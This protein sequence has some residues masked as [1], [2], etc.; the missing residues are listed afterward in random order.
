MVFAL[1][2]STLILVAIAAADR[3]LVTAGATF[4]IVG[5]ALFAP[6]Q[7]ICKVIWVRVDSLV[8]WVP[9][10]ILFWSLKVRSRSVLIKS[11]VSTGRVQGNNIHFSILQTLGIPK[12]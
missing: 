2:S 1:T 7:A 3:V 10:K 4:V 12:M 5:V 6:P 8:L 9:P 11:R